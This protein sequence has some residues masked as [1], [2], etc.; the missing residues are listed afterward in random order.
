MRSLTGGVQKTRKVP[1]FNGRP[2]SERGIA[3]EH[4]Q[5]WGDQDGTID[6]RRYLLNPELKAFG[7]CRRQDTCTFWTGSALGEPP[8]KDVAPPED[9]FKAKKKEEDVASPTSAPGRSFR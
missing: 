7:A 9:P 5:F 6:F 4:G 3:E 2:L 1:W 8:K